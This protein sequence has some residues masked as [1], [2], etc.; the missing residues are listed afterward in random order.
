MPVLHLFD[1]LYLQVVGL[2]LHISY[3]IVLE[4]FP[5]KY[6]EHF[7]SVNTNEKKIS[8]LGA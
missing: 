7:F 1:I 3:G 4:Q 2:S 6:A 5:E 8:V